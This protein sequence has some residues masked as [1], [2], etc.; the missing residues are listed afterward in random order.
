MPSFKDGNLQSFVI[1]S[2]KH[3]KYPHVAAENGV[4]GRVYLE[5]IV[6]KDGSLSEIVLLK[7]PDPA[8]NNEALRVIGTSPRW[9]PGKNNGIPVRVKCSMMIKFVLER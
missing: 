3:L 2:Q 1:W 9:S 4:E 8:L 6:E 7:G 5:F